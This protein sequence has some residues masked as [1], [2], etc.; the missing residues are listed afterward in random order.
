MNG[1]DETDEDETIIDDAGGET[2]IDDEG[3]ETIIDEQQVE[4]LS[5]G[6]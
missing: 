2:I 5:G 4:Q 3:G 1:P 6:K